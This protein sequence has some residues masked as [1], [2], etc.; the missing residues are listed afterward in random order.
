MAS[1]TPEQYVQLQKRRAEKL[2]KNQKRGK[3]RG[4]ELYATRLRM[5]VP[6]QTGKLR[7][8]IVRRGST[9]RVGATGEGGFPYVHWINQTPGK[10][11]ITLDV[12]PK[13]PASRNLV[14]IRGRPVNV[15]GGKM[16]YG[17]QPGNW[18]WTGKVRFAQVALFETRKDWQV[19]I[20]K[21]NKKSIMVQSI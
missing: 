21:I 7:R 15:E 1:Y 3:I 2:L 18:R 11:M 4:A 19:L 14:Y 16:T 5:Y 13:G 17:L 8:S 10:G 20:Q 9:V 12:K 6:V